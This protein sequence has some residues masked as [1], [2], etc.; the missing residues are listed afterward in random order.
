LRVIIIIIS[1]NSSISDTKKL[2]IKAS[3]FGE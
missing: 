1:N 3:K 2:K